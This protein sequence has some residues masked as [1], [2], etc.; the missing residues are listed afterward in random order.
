MTSRWL[1]TIAL[2]LL[3]LTAPAMADF[4]GATMDVTCSQQTDC[5]FGF[6]F[7]TPLGGG[8]YTFGQYTLT[9][10]VLDETGGPVQLSNLT[11]IWTLGGNNLGLDLVGGGLSCDGTC[12]ITYSDSGFFGPLGNGLLNAQVN[13]TLTGG[14]DKAHIE[15]L[16]EV[17]PE[18]P[19]NEVP[20]PGTL[21][22]LGSGLLAGAGTLRRRLRV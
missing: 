16:L 2:S 5:N 8:P 11:A 14:G 7:G 1:A 4:I 21:A 22:L 15:F 3:V 6:G 13:F 9:A 19:G 17:F 18:Q 10:T 12:F 20:E